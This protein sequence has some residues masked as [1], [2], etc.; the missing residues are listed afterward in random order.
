MS[1]NVFEFCEPLKVSFHETTSLGNKTERFTGETLSHT[2]GPEA[3]AP[4][5][6]APREPAPGAEQPG[7]PWPVQHRFSPRGLAGSTV[8]WGGRSKGRLGT[9]LPL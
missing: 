7:D 4:G 3:P 8:S 1:M 9:L 2:R 5:G 6:V